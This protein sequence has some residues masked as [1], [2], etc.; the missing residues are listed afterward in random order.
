M[1]YKQNKI[2]QF[3]NLGLLPYQQAWDFQTQLFD[4]VIA[5]KN[6]NRN[7]AEEGITLT[8]NYL[9]FLEHP[10]V[11]TLGKSGKP[12]N[13]LISETE[14]IEKGIEYFPINRGGDITFHGPQ[15][16]VGYPI[17]DLENFFTDIHKYLRLMEEAIILTCAD[18]GVEA[19]RSEGF[20]GVWIENRK[21]CAIG[22]RT[23]RWVSM[24]GF[25][26]NINTDLGY[27]KN[28]IPCNISDK[29]VTSLERETGKKQDF[30]E[31]SER[32]KYHLASLFE[33][34]I[35]PAKLWEKA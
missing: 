16:L 28:I 11:Y 25:A 8:N 31:V 35:V 3:E 1:T 9:L 23:S 20:T 15:Q 5:Q 19:G 14:L 33:M 6:A 27:F 4:G 10:P 24:H 7:L 12:E 21:I 32:V 13:L 17:L 29:D 26:F 30:I 2:V 34:Q 18:Y 22:V